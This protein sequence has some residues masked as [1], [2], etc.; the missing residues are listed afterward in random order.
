M[1]SVVGL[2]CGSEGVTVGSGARTTTIAVAE[3]SRVGVTVRGSSNEATEDGIISVVHVTGVVV[4]GARTQNSGGVGCPV[5]SL[6][7]APKLHETRVSI[8]SMASD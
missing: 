7:V 6:K 8:T 4:V 1:D 3:T 2:A 5:S